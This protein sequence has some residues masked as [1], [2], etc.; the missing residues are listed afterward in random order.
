MGHRTGPKFA[1]EQPIDPSDPPR[2]QPTTWS[3]F[4]GVKAEHFNGALSSIRICTSQNELVNIN[5]ENKCAE[6]A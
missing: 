5:D 4:L 6:A 2:F 3:E 1:I